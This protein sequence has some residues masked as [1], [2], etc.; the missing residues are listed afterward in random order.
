MVY[1][2][3]ARTSRLM[4]SAESFECSPRNTVNLQPRPV[5]VLRVRSYWLRP[6]LSIRQDNLR[7]ILG[8][9]PGVYICSCPEEAWFEHFGIRRQDYR[10]TVDKKARMFSHLAAGS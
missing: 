1:V 5:Q 2:S 4:N 9:D 8:S 7:M 10:A 3:D 6:L